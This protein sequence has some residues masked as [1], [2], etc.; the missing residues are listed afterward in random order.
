MPRVQYELPVHTFQVDFGGVVSNTVYV[1]WME[2][3][4]T[5]L[6]EA[7]GLPVE[8]AWE[9]GIV[10]VVVHTSIDYRKPLRLGDRVRAEVWISDLRNTSARVEHRFCSGDGVLVAEGHQVGLFVDRE[11]LRPHRLDPALRARLEAVCDG[12]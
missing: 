6:L 9:R 5:T 7:A 4:R 12:E 11:T 10:P 2:I 8:A 1:Q 3:G